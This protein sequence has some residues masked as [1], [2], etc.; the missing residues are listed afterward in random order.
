MELKL[1]T[2]VQNYRLVTPYGQ[3]AFLLQRP[4]T[5]EG[6][7]SDEVLVRE[8]GASKKNAVSFKKLENLAAVDEGCHTTH[9]HGILRQSDPGQGY[10][11]GDQVWLRAQ[12][13]KRALNRDNQDKIEV[14]NLR[15]WKDLVVPL[16]RVLWVPTHRRLGRDG[17]EEELITLA[18]PLKKRLCANT[19]TL[20]V[21]QRVRRHELKVEV[22]ELLEKET[23]T[24]DCQNL[25][26]M[27]GG[28]AI[29]EEICRRV[30]AVQD[31]MSLVHATASTGTSIDTR[32]HSSARWREMNVATALATPPRSLYSSSSAEDDGDDDEDDGD[33]EEELEQSVQEMQNLVEARVRRSSPRVRRVCVPYYFPLDFRLTLHRSL[34]SILFT[35]TSLQTSTI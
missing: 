27:P 7:D 11:E 6:W 17:A 10:Q 30:L 24:H 23:F 15:T 31:H 3:S 19:Y 4:P 26:R 1:T 9:V 22:R 25:R 8:D 32:T 21:V 12:V 29:T 34:P 20:A 33:D 14:V 13:W 16:G 35:L 5:V 18:G 2:D 28:N